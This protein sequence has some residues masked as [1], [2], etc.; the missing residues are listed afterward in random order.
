MISESGYSEDTYVEGTR[1]DLAREQMVETIRSS[2]TIPQIMLKKLGEY[3][4]Q[5]R[6]VD[7]FVLNV[8]DE[9]IG[10]IDDQELNRLL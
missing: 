1:Q 2:L 4:L 5:E 9:K 6:S 8:K 10:K 3:N 7:Y